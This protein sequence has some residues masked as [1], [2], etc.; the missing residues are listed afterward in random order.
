MTKGAIL[1]ANEN[2]ISKAHCDGASETELTRSG[3]FYRPQVDILE[4]ADGLLVLADVPGARGD[5]I[6]VKFEDG[7]LSIHARLEPRPPK[8]QE[9]LRQEYG[10]GDYYRTFQVSEA[11]AAQKITADY[12][13]GVLAL[14]LPK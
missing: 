1:M 3:R 12:C 2:T 8:D 5:Q 6:D 13:D 9:Y 7:N 14:P 11:V 4:Q 10:V